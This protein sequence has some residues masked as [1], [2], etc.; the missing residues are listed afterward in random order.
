[1]PKLKNAPL[2]AQRICRAIFSPS[3]MH[4]QLPKI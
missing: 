4:K 3:I 2:E 1:L